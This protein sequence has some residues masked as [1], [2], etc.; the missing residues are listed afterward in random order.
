MDLKTNLR[1]FEL[2]V[3]GIFERGVSVE[4]IKELKKK[5]ELA[6]LHVH[7]N[8]G[9]YNDKMLK[10]AIGLS[11]EFRDDVTGFEEKLQELKAKDLEEAGSRARVEILDQFMSS[12]KEGFNLDG[13][14]RELLPDYHKAADKL[15]EIM[16]K[17]SFQQGE[18]EY[19][20]DIKAV[21]VNI[22]EEMYAEARNEKRKTLSEYTP[23][24]KAS[25][26]PSVSS[27]YIHTLSRDDRATR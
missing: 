1:G 27:Q 16:E 14:G 15:E 2:T 12:I 6:E 25:V 13:Q 24:A 26:E 3:R 19:D 23:E 22:R 20:E 18:R 11:K 5:L 8:D 9:N 17:S 10:R 4:N 21:W 7:I